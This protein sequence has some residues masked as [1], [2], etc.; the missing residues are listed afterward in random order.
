MSRVPDPSSSRPPS[1][2]NRQATWVRW[3]FR[4]ET[5]LRIPDSE[6]AST[7]CHAFSFQ[8]PGH[9]DRNLVVAADQVNRKHLSRPVDDIIFTDVVAKPSASEPKA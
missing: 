9:A 2:S 7:S 3:T 1:T 8:L 6:V 5:D 4:I